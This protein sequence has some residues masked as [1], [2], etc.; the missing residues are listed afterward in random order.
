MTIN[1]RLIIDNLPCANISILH[2]LNLPKVFYIRYLNYHIFTQSIY[3]IL[4]C[5]IWRLTKTLIF[6]IFL[7][8]ESQII[9]L[10]NNIYT[11][12]RLRIFH[13]SFIFHWILVNFQV[14]PARLLLCF[15]LRCLL[16]FK[17][18]LFILFSWRQFWTLRPLICK[19]LIKE[20][21]V[22]S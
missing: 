6:F 1:C 10:L 2:L 16:F 7:R 14:Y 22:C 18:K 13:H 4:T 3:S 12:V 19:N 15:K 5:L 8:R 11:Y 17:G 21:F 20:I 9:E